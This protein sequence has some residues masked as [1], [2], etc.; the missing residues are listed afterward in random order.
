ME[1]AW[2]M[3]GSCCR[4]NG[5][6]RDDTEAAAGRVDGSGV[7]MVRLNLATRH[8]SDAGTVCGQGQGQGTVW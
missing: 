3:V 6:H 2:P 4:S 8:A 7:H 1:A 5:S